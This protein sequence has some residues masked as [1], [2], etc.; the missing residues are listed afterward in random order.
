MKIF[1]IKYM[2]LALAVSALAISCNDDDDITDPI[3]ASTDFTGTFVQ[4]DQMGRPGINTVFPTTNAQENAFNVT[5]P[6]NQISQWQGVFSDKVDGLYAAYS[7]TAGTTLEYETNILGLNQTLLTTALA[8][9]VLQVAPNATGP[10]T[11]FESTS[12][13]LTGRRLQDDVIDVSLILLFGGNDGARFDGDNGTPEL[14][15]DNVGL[16]SGVTS[17]TFPYLVPASF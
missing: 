15:T 3:T 6:A 5:I 4:E 14:V 11:Y 13:F 1:N 17:T 9:D 10:T 2:V 12:N 7:N 8:L 16:E